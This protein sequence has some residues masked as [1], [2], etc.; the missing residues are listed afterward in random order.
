MVAYGH[1]P[2]MVSAQCVTRT[3]YGCTKKPDILYMKDRTGKQLPVKNHCRFCYNTIYNPAPF[4]LLGQEQTVRRLHPAVLRLQFSVEDERQIRR[5]TEA[6]I[7]HFVYGNDVP[8]PFA[9]FTR[10]HLKRGVE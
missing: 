7:Q 4:S 8:A 5:V 10:G 9:D 2:A 1:F 6:Y 3:R